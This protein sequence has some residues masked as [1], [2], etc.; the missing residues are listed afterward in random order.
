ML[1]SATSMLVRYVQNPL[2]NPTEEKF[3]KIRKGNAAFAKIASVPGVTAFLSAAGFKDNGE[4]FE[5]ENE[6]DEVLRQ[7]KEALERFVILATE[8]DENER[9]AAVEAR[10]RE[11][12]QREE[13][14]K[15]LLAKIK[16]DAACRKE[17]GWSA[18]VSASAAK[19]GKAISSF[20]DLVKG[21]AQAQG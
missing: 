20:S 21:E 4:F 6:N 14:K 13:E 18:K 17:E 7:A 12:R 1:S 19:G 5:L 10:L 2:D 3:R 11:S 16:N 8:K 15:A 9:R